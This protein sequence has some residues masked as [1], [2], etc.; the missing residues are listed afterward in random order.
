MHAAM[1]E[2]EEEMKDLSTGTGNH[3]ATEVAKGFFWQTPGAILPYVVSLVVL[4]VFGEAMNGRNH[5]LATKVQYAIVVG[6]GAVPSSVVMLLTVK[7]FQYQKK[8]LLPS[9]SNSRGNPC[10]IIFGNRDILF[11]LLGTGLS[12]ALYDFVYYGTALN[13]PEIFG[14][15]FHGTGLIANAWQN[16]GAFFMGLPGVISAIWV[17]RSVGPKMLQAWGFVAIGSAS[18]VLAVFLSS[19]SAETPAFLASY[20]LI[21]TLNWGCNVS[22]CLLFSWHLS[23]AICSDIC[24]LM[25]CAVCIF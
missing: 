10:A 14:R 19:N 6:V 17:L 8:D 5:L 18:M 20:L 3:R 2:Y 16:L 7:Q 12:W 13:L 24:S 25:F 9:I 1:A 23:S 21:F 22:F 11:K 15:M 4:F